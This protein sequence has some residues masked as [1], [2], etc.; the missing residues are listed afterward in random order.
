MMNIGTQTNSLI[1]HMYSCASPHQA[2]VL[3][4]DGCTLLHWTDRSPATVVAVKA[5]ASKIY[6]NLIE[7]R[8]DLC[9]VIAGSVHDGS[10]AYKFSVNTAAPKKLYRQRI[11]DGALIGCYYND[12]DRLVN[13]KGGSGVLLGKREK[14]VDPSF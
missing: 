1:N 9:E 4:G 13:C 11:A 2:A 6:S 7:V 8:E 14:Y 12:S 10:A 5:L 3:V